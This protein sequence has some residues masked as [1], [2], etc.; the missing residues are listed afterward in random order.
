MFSHSGPDAII[1]VI[2]FGLSKEHEACSRM[3]TVAGTSFYMSP[4]VI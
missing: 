3:K 1:K 2:D 4:E